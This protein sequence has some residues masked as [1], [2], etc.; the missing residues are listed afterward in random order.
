LSRVVL[1]TG[2]LI[3]VLRSAEAAEAIIRRR[4]RILLSAVVHAELVRGADTKVERAY[5][6]QLARHHPPAAPTARQWAK[7]GAVLARFR[8]EQHFDPA[9]IRGIQNDVLIALLARDH[10]V[11]VVTTDRA[12]FER[13]AGLVRG[14]GVLP[15]TLEACPTRS[16]TP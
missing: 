15:W 3:E 4:W 9:G 13:I 2:V 5:V 6:A 12:D 7:C 16:R 14:V 8:R 10:G 1:D 11:P